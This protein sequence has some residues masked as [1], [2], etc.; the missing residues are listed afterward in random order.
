[1]VQ[2]GAGPWQRTAPYRRDQR[3]VEELVQRV[4]RTALC[5][6]AYDVARAA[7]TSTGLQLEESAELS[8]HLRDVPATLLVRVR[9]ALV[10][11]GG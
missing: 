11:R 7:R 5:F 4:G 6:T 8:R 1:M 2:R 9:S 3:R 10:V